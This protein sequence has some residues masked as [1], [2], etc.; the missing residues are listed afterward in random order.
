MKSEKRVLDLWKHLFSRWVLDP[1][2]LGCDLPQSLADLA[3]DAKPHELALGGKGM[4]PSLSAS[5]L[6]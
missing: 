1:Q 5:E 2:L 6:T 3:P 4:M